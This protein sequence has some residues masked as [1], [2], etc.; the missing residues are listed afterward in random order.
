MKISIKDPNRKTIVVIVQ[1]KAG[2]DGNYYFEVKHNGKG[3]LSV[4]AIVMICFFGGFLVL[5]CSLIVLVCCVSCF[6][7]KFKE[8]RA[9]YLMKRQ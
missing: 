8:R 3:G 4:I 7:K 1:G 2:S 5:A 9:E 6:L